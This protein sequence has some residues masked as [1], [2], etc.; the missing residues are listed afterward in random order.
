M[1]IAGVHRQRLKLMQNLFISLIYTKKWRYRLNWRKT[2]NTYTKGWPWIIKITNVT[3]TV[4]KLIN[5]VG[6]YI[7]KS[8]IIYFKYVLS[9]RS[10]GRQEDRKTEQRTDKQTETLMVTLRS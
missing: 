9:M 4:I 1:V 3:I 10:K 2:D 6:F 5:K 8:T 7:I